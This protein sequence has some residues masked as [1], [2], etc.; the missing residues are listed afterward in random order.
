MIIPLTAGC[1]GL[2]S[3]TTL[4][5]LVHE[6]GRC[7]A[8]VHFTDFVNLAGELEDAFGGSGFTGVN[9]GKDANIPITIQVSH[10]GFQSKK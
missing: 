6:V 1:S 9:V 7:R 4:L 8:I 5:L 10:C 3:D 2:D